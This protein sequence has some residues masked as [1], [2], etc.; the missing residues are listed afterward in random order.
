MKNQ[1]SI[2]E[3][4]WE[5]RQDRNLKQ[6][7]VAAAAG[8]TVSTLSKYENKDNKA[9]NLDV[10]A[11]LAKYYDVS[12]EWLAGNTEVRE[13]NDTE[14]DELKLDDA[15]IELLKSGRFNN[16][17]LCEII[18]HPDFIRLMT[19]TEIYVDGIATMQI[20]NM[21]DWLDAVRLQIIRQNNPETDEL[22]LQVLE[23]SH[24]QEEEYFFHTFHSDWDSIV[25]TIREAHQ[26]A[27]ESAP[28]ERPVS[29]NK[30]VQRFINTLK[31]KSNPVEE[32]WRLFCDELQIPYDHLSVQEHSTM[33]GIFKKSKLL[34]A[35]PNLNHKGQK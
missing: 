27:A 26:N 9:Y 20:K 3:R 6:D 33:K 30:R 35:F 1:L 22:Y 10:L 12:L 29:V 23:R 7:V 15:T 28:I 21:N 11:K 8:I 31:F 24:I 19:D 34:K 5:L 16:R 18:K 25:R 17:L 4:L 2:Q 32:F 14:I 13:V